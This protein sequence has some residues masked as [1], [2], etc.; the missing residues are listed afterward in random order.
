M[1][2]VLQVLRLLQWLQWLQWL[3]RARQHLGWQRESWL[4]SIRGG[5]RISSDVKFGSRVR[6]PRPLSALLIRPSTR[7]GAGCRAGGRV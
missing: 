6:C 5:V 7:P 1:L 2:Q 4:P 3:Q